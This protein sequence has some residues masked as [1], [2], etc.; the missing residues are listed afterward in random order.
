MLYEWIDNK[1]TNCCDVRAHVVYFSHFVQM[2]SSRNITISPD[3]SR[4][5]PARG[6]LALIGSVIDKIGKLEDWEIGKLPGPA[7]L[8]PQLVR[9]HLVMSDV[10]QPRDA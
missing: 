4:P 6:W 3:V 10:T 9:E 1:K 2:Q 5:A 8:T 7:S